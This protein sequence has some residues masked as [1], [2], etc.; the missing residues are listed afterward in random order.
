MIAIIVTLYVNILLN[1]MCVRSLR[2]T[3][4]KMSRKLSTILPFFTGISASISIFTL[5]DLKQRGRLWEDF[6]NALSGI[7][8]SNVNEVD[9]LIAIYWIL[10][11]SCLTASFVLSIVYER[12]MSR[13]D[14]HT[15]TFINVV[16]MKNHGLTLEVNQLVAEKQKLGN[17]LESV[18]AN[19]SSM[20]DVL[21]PKG[22]FYVSEAVK[23]SRGKSAEASIFHE[24]EENNLLVDQTVM[25]INHLIRSPLSGVAFCLADIESQEISPQVSE[26]IKRIKIYLET[27]EDNINSLKRDIGIIEDNCEVDVGIEMKKRLEVGLLS[28]AKNLHLD[29]VCNNPVIIKGR[30]FKNIMACVYC[31][32]ENAVF[33]SRD[34]GLIKVTIEENDCIEIR[35]VNYGPHIAEPDKMFDPGYSSKETSGIGLSTA[36]EIAE[37][38]GGTV[39]GENLRLEEPGIGV[40][41]T[42]IVPSAS[43]KIVKEEI[44]APSEITVGI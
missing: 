14:V 43:A 35:I 37:K 23:E 24:V 42:I 40:Q 26:R 11:L 28:N 31:I 21:S 7:N 30:K 3:K 41:F 27:I 33:F 12:K 44:Y 19:L 18:N 38:M 36:R 39:A 15:R 16:S 32:V 5:M 2:L 29:Y 25:K 17:K 20:S 9:A 13:E 8:I 34:N 6:I 10:T 22:A 1:I 4:K